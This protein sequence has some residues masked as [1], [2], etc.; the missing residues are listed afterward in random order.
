M[1]ETCLEVYRR[2]SFSKF[3]FSAEEY[4]QLNAKANLINFCDRFRGVSKEFLAVSKLKEDAVGIKFLKASV[5]YLFIVEVCVFSGFLKFFDVH[6]MAS[7]Q[8]L[9]NFI[10]SKVLLT[11]FFA[12]NISETFE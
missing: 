8:D 4:I 2:K 11:L 12:W 3:L 1:H 10:V 7:T 6:I 9:G 5:P